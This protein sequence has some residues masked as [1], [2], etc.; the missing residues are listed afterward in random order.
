MIS[1]LTMLLQT[2]KIAHQR[3]NNLFLQHVT[4]PGNPVAPSFSYS[5]ICAAAR[6]AWLK[7]SNSTSNQ[8]LT[9][10]SDDFN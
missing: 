10:Q 5:K 7:A 2:A 9:V 3:L 8:T 1:K 4:V 6:L